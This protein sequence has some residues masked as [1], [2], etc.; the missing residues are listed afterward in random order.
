[1][2]VSVLLVDDRQENRMALKAILSASDYRLVEASSGAE[3]LRR[4]L[5]EEFA[6]LLVDVVMPEMSGFELASAIKQ[7]ERTAAIPILFLTAHA[8]EVDLVYKGYQVGAVDYL[9]KPLNPEMV[10]AKV[11]VFAELYRQRKRNEQQATLLLQAE[12]KESELR[13]VELRLAGERRY[14]NLAEAVPQI[15]WTARP[16]GTIDYFNQRWFEFTG[17]SAEQAAGSWERAVYPEDLGGWQKCWQEALASGRMLQAECRL[18][19]AENGAFRWHLCR[20]VPEVG[21]GG[22]IIS[23]LGTFTD[24]EDQKRAHEVLAE[25][26]G[27]LDV[28]LDAVMIFEPRTW[29]FLYLNHGASALLGYRQQELLRMRPFEFMSDLGESQFRELLAPLEDEAKCAVTVETRCRKKD[30]KEIPV[31][32]SFQLVQVNGGHVVSIA[33]DI[34]ERKLEELEREDLYR[35]ALAA[36][37]ARDEFLSV[38]SHELKTPL[39]SLKLQ[40]GMLNRAREVEA[41]ALSF[42]QVMEKVAAAARQVDRLSGLVAKLMDVSS[43]KAGRLHL[44]LQEVNLAAIASDVVS[45]FKE[46]AAKVGCDVVLEATN[47]IPGRWDPLRME[48]VVTNL[49]ANALKFGAGKPVEVTVTA[50]EGESARLV[51]RDHGIGIAPEDAERIFQRFERAVVARSYAGLGLGLYIV[52]QIV[53]AHEGTICVESQPGSGSTFTIH[54]P[55]E[56]RRAFEQPGVGEDAGRLTFRSGLNDC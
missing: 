24:I 38:A 19:Q 56:A 27:T 51:V 2:Q 32:L 48:Q 44:E 5:D 22:Q 34:T 13:L 40:L 12:R 25:F 28:V 36:V 43:I 54:I 4:L 39:S 15:I 42:E 47:P 49:L 33:R 37:R 55:F 45:R 21:P 17:L 53:E 1:M 16:N 14:R 23:W 41:H 6:V 11:A 7:R 30:G 50:G 18:Q 52:R 3:A 35:E 20:A 10:R 31:E 8:T 46:D 29:R 26:K 9:V